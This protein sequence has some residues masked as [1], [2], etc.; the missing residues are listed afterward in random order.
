[1]RKGRTEDDSDDENVGKNGD[2][3]SRKKRMTKG[4]RRI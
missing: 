2:R 4:T 1:M 3:R